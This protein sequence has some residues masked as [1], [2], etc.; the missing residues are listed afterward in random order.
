MAAVGSYALNPSFTLLA[1]GGLNILNTEVDGA[2]A[3][4]NGNDGDT[5][6]SWSL[7]LGAQY[8]FTPAVGLRVEW[9][10][11]FEVGDSDSTGEA[12]I[13]MITAGVVYKF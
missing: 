8:N 5:D 1:R 2:I 7:G 6:V 11:F 10:R 3:G 9:E 4:P 13:D 12:D